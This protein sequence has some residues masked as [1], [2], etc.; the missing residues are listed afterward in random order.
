MACC[1]GLTQLFFGGGSGGRGLHENFFQN[2]LSISPAP[3]SV[4]Q[5]YVE[6]VPSVE[7][8]PWRGYCVTCWQSVPRVT[9]EVVTG[10]EGTL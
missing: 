2:S 5:G 4:L 1:C 3:S 8:M 6:V 7:S 9:W 10:L